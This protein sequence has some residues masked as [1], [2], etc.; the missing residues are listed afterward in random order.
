MYE[1]SL[2]FYRF[3]FC[4]ILNKLNLMLTCSLWSLFHQTYP[5]WVEF[6]MG[7]KI[8]FSHWIKVP[9]FSR[10]SKTLHTIFQTKSLDLCL[11]NFIPRFELRGLLEQFPSAKC[12]IT[13]HDFFLFYFVWMVRFPT[14]LDQVGKKINARL[15]A[16]CWPFFWFCRWLFFFFGSMLIFNFLLTLASTLGS[17]ISC[18]DICINLIS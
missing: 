14:A 13:L 9:S 5:S 7:T 16:A 8:F 15:L 12:R 18:S 3:I 4:F 10:T 1:I 17:A 6:G 11:P 2:L